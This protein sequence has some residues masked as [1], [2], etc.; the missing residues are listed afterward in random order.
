MADTLLSNVTTSVSVD[1]LIS[2]VTTDVL[3]ELPI[4]TIDVN[5]ILYI[6]FIIIFAYVLNRLLGFILTHIS[7]RMGRYRTTITMLIPL[8]K[9]VVYVVALYYIIIAVIEPSLTLLLAFSGLF[10]A[11][12]GFGLKDLFADIIAG[13]IIIFEK[14]YQIGDMVS[15]GEKYGEVKNIGIRSTRLQTPGDEQVSAPNGTIFTQSVTS[16]NAGDLAMMIVIDL[17]VHP[18]SD[19]EMAMKILKEALVTSKYVIISKRYTHTV[20]LD[21]F[22]FYKR[23]RAKGYVNDLRFEFEF[24]SEVSRRALAEFRKVGIRPPSFVPPQGVVSHL[25]DEV[26]E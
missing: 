8:L 11:A 19:A 18:D 7:E 12:I 5:L 15:I 21:D 17:Y 22:P 16:G 25:L 23:V 14:P 3:A 20:L 2:N 1:T 13:I 6:L 10:G 4:K 9:L 26:A 24:K